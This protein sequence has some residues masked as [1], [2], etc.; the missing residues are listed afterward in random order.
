MRSPKRCASEKVSAWVRCSNTVAHR[1]T[2]GLVQGLQADWNDCIQFGTTGESMFSTFLLA[3]GLRVVA[4]LAEHTGRE[5]AAAW[6][7]AELEA[8]EPVLESA[9]DGEW[10]IRGISATGAKLGSH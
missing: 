1:G 8:L 5:E 6:A 7:G 9:W 10:Y 4:E 2:N 3:N